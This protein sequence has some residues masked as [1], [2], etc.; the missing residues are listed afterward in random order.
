MLAG[1][2][3]RLNFLPLVSI[4]Q[5]DAEPDRLGVS[6]GIESLV[7]T[8]NEQVHIDTLRAAFA[9]NEED[10]VIKG[11]LSLHHLERN[12]LLTPGMKALPTP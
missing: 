5:D 7:S 12:E 4:H 6:Q 1:S 3:W 8:D 11:A 9:Q 2:P 10:R